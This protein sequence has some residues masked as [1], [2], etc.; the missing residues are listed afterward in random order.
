MAKILTELPQKRGGVGRKPIYPYDEW[1]DG[2]IRLLESGVDFKAKSASV[3]ASIRAT[4]KDRKMTV[5]IRPMGDDL[6]IQARA[7][8]P[9]VTEQEEA[10]KDNGTTIPKSDTHKPKRTRTTA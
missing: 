10:A 5:A 6:A 1:L 3:A 2:Q 7:M 4:A 9:E 8:E